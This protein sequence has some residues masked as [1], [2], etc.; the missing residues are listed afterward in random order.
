M[1]YN[2]DKEKNEEREDFK[3]KLINFFQKTEAKKLKIIGT[4]ILPLFIRV[5]LFCKKVKEEKRKL[6]YNKLNV[7]ATTPRI[8]IISL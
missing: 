5:K 8:T 2:L 3:M 1:E 4:L 6:K 7:T